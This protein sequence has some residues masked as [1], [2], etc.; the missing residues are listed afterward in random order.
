MSSAH[1]QRS[2]AAKFIDNI[3]DGSRITDSSFRRRHR[4]ILLAVALQIPFLFGVSRLAGTE[5]FTG[6]TLP[7]I[8]VVESFIGAG[9]VA[10]ALGV[11]IAPFLPR[12]VRSATAS[13]AFMLSASVLAYFSGG[14][15][16]AHFLYFV[17]VG[18][19]AAYEDWVPF[20]VA[21]GYVGFQHSVFGLLEGVTVYNHPAAMA[22][23]VKWGMIHAFL[24]ACLAVAVLAQWQ[25]VSA[26]RDR[27]EE[28][29]KDVKKAKANVEEERERAEQQK[30]EAQ[31]AREEAEAKR[32]EAQQQRERVRD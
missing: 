13:F 14:F 5:S 15:I 12:R 4:A 9:L 11:G 30:Q 17:G 23:P 16:E 3:P 27:V 8:P 7:E 18:V 26:A 1:E 6:A 28:K 29:L 10:A 2:G 21:I 25:S 22:N 32:Q 19:V 31:A 24:V 20:A